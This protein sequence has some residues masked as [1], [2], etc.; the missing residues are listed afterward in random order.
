MSTRTFRE[1]LTEAKIK[2]FYTEMEQIT[3]QLCKFENHGGPEIKH[4]KEKMMSLIQEG[5]IEPY[6]IKI[7]SYDE[8]ALNKQFKKD[9]IIF[10]YDDSQELNGYYDKQNDEIHI[11]YSKD[12]TYE[13]IEAMV[14]HEFIHKI[15]H[16]R[17]GE[18]YFKQ[19]E[20]AI[21]ELN[22]I[23]NKLKDLSKNLLVHRKEFDKLNIL[24]AEKLKHFQYLS[25]YEKMAYAYQYVKN[26][27]NKD[28]Y[29]IL[30]TIKFPEM[31]NDAKFRKYI[32]MYWLIRNKI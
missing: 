12:D 19:S 22:D 30:E 7:N 25:S 9:K 17:A 15:Q 32:G 5:I 28:P 4:I 6:M 27:K 29:D 20:K 23:F 11:I 18:N 24:Y 8:T 10:Q 2:K 31:R 16:K 13:Q 14:G 26:N 1:F 21:K 3:K